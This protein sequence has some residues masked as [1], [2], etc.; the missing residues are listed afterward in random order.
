[1]QSA[2]GIA[3]ECARDGVPGALPAQV[4]DHATG[5]LAAFGTLV[6]LARRA[7]QG[8]SYLVRVSLAQ[9]GHWFKGLGRIEE[10]GIAEPDNADIADLLELTQTPFGRI[11]HLQAAVAKLSETPAYWMLPSVPL[12]S[13]APVWW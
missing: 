1:V 6:A 4:Q 3:W 9:T 5:Y 2:S 7:T 13:H 12:G 10:S 8:G 11:Q